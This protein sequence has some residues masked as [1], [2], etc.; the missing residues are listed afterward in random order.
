[1]VREDRSR[2]WYPVRRDVMRRRVVKGC[3]RAPVRHR[4]TGVKGAQSTSVTPTD[5][6]SMCGLLVKGCRDGRPPPTRQEAKGSEMAQYTA[7]APVPGGG[8]GS[9]R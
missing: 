3:R 1:M 7:F 4:R 9:G 8:F 6:T 2:S 5:A